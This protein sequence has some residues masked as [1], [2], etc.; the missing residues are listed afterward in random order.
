MK[1]CNIS[2]VFITVNSSLLLFS[3]AVSQDTP[4]SSSSS[5]S[6]SLSLSA[7]LRLLL[8]PEADCF[9]NTSLTSGVSVAS[10]TNFLAIDDD[11]RDGKWL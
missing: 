5:K 3:I 7:G 4:S 10:P 6:S 11:V 9:P 1:K 8:P 2:T